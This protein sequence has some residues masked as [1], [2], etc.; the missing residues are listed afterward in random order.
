MSAVQI[1]AAESPVPVVVTKWGISP[2]T[3]CCKA[4]ATGTGGLVVLDVD[5]NLVV[6]R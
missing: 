1:V 3:P 4:A 6:Q 5:A 2:L